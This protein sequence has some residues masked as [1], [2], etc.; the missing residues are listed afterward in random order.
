MNLRYL[1]DTNIC[2][3]IMKNRPQYL[4]PI[5]AQHARELCI[6]SITVMELEYGVACSQ[7]QVSNA[8]KLAGFLSRLTILDFDSA[9]AEHAARIR[10]H[11]RQ[12]GTPIGAYDALIAGHARSL[13]LTVVT[14]DVRE[15]ERVPG[16]MFENWLQQP[17]QSQLNEPIPAY[18]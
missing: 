13:G 17:P 2:I 1:L 5:F 3:Y 15:F 8:E 12:C 16:L 14:N 4:A 11:L 7:Q 18:R 9:A 10:A 6:S